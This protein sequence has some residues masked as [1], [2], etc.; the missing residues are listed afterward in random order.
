MSPEAQ[1]AT[2]RSARHFILGTAGHIDHGKSTL[3]KALTGVDPDR[4]PEEKARGM[5]IEL[6]FA[7]LPIGG[8]HFG[9][10]DVPG[11][12]K[13]V[14]TMVA[15][16]TG[17]DVALLVVAADDG[18]MP[19]TREHAQILDLLGIEHGCIA[20]TKIDAVPEGRVEEVRSQIA[21]LV[22][23]T[24]LESFPVTAT[25]STTG[26][27]LD[28]LR[29][30]LAE[31]ADRIAED[32]ESSVFRMAIDRVFAIRGRGTVVTGSVLSGRVQ[33]GDT[34]ELMPGCL[35]V[36]VREVQTHGCGRGLVARGQ[37]AA[38]NLTGVKHEQIRRGHELASP[39]FLQPSR[40]VDASVRV[41]ADAPKPVL[42]HST[43]R[44]CVGTTE[45]PARLVVFE[46]KGISPGERAAAQLRPREPVVAQHGQRFIIRHETASHTIGGGV[47]LRPV[48]GRTAA[49]FPDNMAGLA[50]LSSERAADRLG[51]TL[52][53]A[54][55]GELSDSQ[56]ACRSGV[57]PA[58]VAPLRRE[59][60]AAGVLV[61]VEGIKRPV[62]VE[63]LRDFRR[64]ASAQLERWHDRHKNEPGFPVQRF[65]NRL[66]RRALP[67]DKKGQAE[68]GKPLQEYLVSSRAVLVRGAFVR[69]PKF[70]PALSAEDQAILTRL[71][72]R[73]QQ[74]AFKPPKT[75]ELRKELGR[76]FGKAER[77]IKYALSEGQL[78]RVDGELL[79][80][81]DAYA[82][83]K[84]KVA[85]L[86]NTGGP[87]TVAQIRQALDSTR[88]F[89]VPFVEHLDRIGFTRRDG[90]TRTLGEM[91]R[92][93]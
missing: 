87:A 14:R 37:R 61:G 76:I 4:L 62:H 50:A 89:V 48:S 1:T 88:K 85:E 33:S 70:A 66:A 51:E 73:Y 41:L 56:A 30:V 2:Q 36:K 57:D 34:L 24:S 92:T 55:F 23:G 22:N 42:S 35:T 64:E 67:G 58:Q 74:A 86:I 60:F 82:Q 54:G 84:E 47:I 52:R 20:V 29:G 3:V 6:G 83:L 26:A 49:R 32:D 80:H 11:H 12:E 40:Y 15:G 91:S 39:G 93:E 63:A 25:S 19:Q 8:H 21:E 77:M 90:D 69:H 13:F 45:T 10:V 68:I 16:A 46:G 43:V 71:L 27:G 31:C 17:I 18:V 38:L 59:L 5:T 72:N 79:L 78:V 7:P 28:E 53:R 65:V 81:A 75:T 9:V 44:L